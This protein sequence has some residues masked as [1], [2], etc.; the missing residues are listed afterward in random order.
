MISGANNEYILGTFLTEEKNRFL[1]TVSVNGTNVTCYIPSS[2]RL[3]NF[4]DLSGRTVLLKR[5]QSTKTRTEY[6]VYAVKDR[7]SFVL[8]NLA[9]A[10]RV[11]ESHLHRRF[12]SFLGNR[13]KISREHAIDSYKSDL[14]IHDTQTIIE[15]KS[16]ISFNNY[17]I[18]PSIYSERALEQLRKISKLLDD[19][20]RVC[21]LLVSLNPRIKEVHLNAD[22]SDFHA[23]FLECVEKGM[24]VKA[25]T[26]RMINHEPQIAGAL[27]VNMPAISE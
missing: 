12:F 25:F 27:R 21:Y 3:S 18:F 17:A 4:I 14:F 8:L 16:I 5:N 15:I 1:C 11:I 20:Y 10:N 24:I 22:G 13:T 6:A 26:T 2:C 9:Q 19:G 23:L 7:K